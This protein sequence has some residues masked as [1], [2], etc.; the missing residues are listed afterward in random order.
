MKFKRWY[1]GHHYVDLDIGKY[2][3]LYNR[4][5][6][7]G[8]KDNVAQK[9]RNNM[10]TRFF[11]DDGTEF[12]SASECQAYE[13]DIALQKYYAE[14]VEPSLADRANH[15][16]KLFQAECRSRRVEDD[17]LDGRLLARRCPCER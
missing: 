15:I 17:L 3:C 5:V 6:R 7:L 16:I 12:K 2:S 1:F 14:F 13:R 8:E 4:I 9:E 11:A 10:Q